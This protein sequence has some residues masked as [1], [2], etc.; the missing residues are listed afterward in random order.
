MHIAVVKWQFWARTTDAIFI[1]MQVHEKFRVVGWKLYF[2]FMDL[3][4]VF[5]IVV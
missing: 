1:V 4:Q 5:D 2:G 3:E